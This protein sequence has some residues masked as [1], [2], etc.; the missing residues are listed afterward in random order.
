LYPGKPNAPIP[1]W[2]Q[3]Y[4]TQ[5]IQMR[6]RLL[7]ADQPLPPGLAATKNVDW[8]AIDAAPAKKLATKKKSASK[9]AK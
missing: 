9:G 5:R 4:D 6:D 8:S 2:K 3:Y 7:F 1:W